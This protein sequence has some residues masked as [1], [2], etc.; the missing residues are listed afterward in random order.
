M[1]EVNPTLFVL[2][3]GLTQRPLIDGEV[4]WVGP[5]DVD[6]MTLVGAASMLAWARIFRRVLECQRSAAHRDAPHRERGRRRAI[7][8][9]VS[10]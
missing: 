1:V 10:C 6:P 2:D 5:S 8:A 4:S 9:P 7:F 3:L